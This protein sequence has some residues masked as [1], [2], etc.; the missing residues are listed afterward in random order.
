MPWGAREDTKI[1]LGE[2]P[3]PVASTKREV[4]EGTDINTKSGELVLMGR[5]MRESATFHSS[6]NEPFLQ[7]GSDGQQISHCCLK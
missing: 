4:K 7:N 3:S 1:N 2:N 5:E 6:V